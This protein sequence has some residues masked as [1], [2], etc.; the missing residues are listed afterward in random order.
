MGDLRSQL[1][2]KLG[3][4]VVEDEE[5]SS[6]PSPL[7][8]TG[9][10]DSKWMEVLRDVLKNIPSIKLKEPPS[11]GNA[12]QATHVALKTLK[13]TGTKRQLAQLKDASD[14]YFKKREKMAWTAV[15]EQFTALNLS[16]KAYRAIKQLNADPEKVL[17]RLNAKKPEELQKLGAK[18]LK[19]AL[20]SS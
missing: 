7:G 3:A 4:T 14:S 13:K 12:R 11:L 8:P 15:K 5:V 10:L 1:I 20:L 18:A 9:H 6:V 2:A 19:E 16:E 17:H